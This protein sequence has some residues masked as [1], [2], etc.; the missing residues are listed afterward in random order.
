MQALYPA[1]RSAFASA[2]I[3]WSTGGF[4]VYSLGPGYTY[5]PADAVIA[6]LA[7]ITGSV[8]LAGMTVL[9]GGVCDATDA[10][11]PVTSGDSTNAIVVAETGGTLVY[12]TDTY[13]SGEPINR[14]SDG[15]D[16]LVAWSNGSG[17]I[18]V[19]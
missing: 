19:I 7:D 14:L 12:F 18:F 1:A 11:I 9:A 8:A 17:R 6:D 5:D 2:G 3:D 15:S 16:T 4:T 10:A 13:T